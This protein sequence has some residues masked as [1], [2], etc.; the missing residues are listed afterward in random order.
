MASDKKS[1]YRSLISRLQGVASDMPGVSE[2]ID[3]IQPLL[4]KGIIINDGQIETDVFS[5]AKSDI[6]SAQDCLYR[7]IR[8]CYTSMYKCE[9]E[10]E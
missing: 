3:D 10:E 6:S 4:D 7:A 5:G 8:S 2:S 1:K 9:E